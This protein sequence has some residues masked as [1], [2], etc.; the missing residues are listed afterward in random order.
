MTTADRGDDPHRLTT[1]PV[2][3]GIDG[4]PGAA[5]AVDWAADAASRRRR[6]LELVHALD[7]MATRGALGVYDVMV[8]PVQDTIRA[9]GV[10][11]LTAAAEAAR[12][13]DPDLDIVVS[14]SE[15]SPARALIERSAVAH[16]LVVGTSGTGGTISHL[17]STLLAVV[18]HGRGAVVVARGADTA[19]VARHEGPVVVGVDGSARGAAAIGA[20]CAEAAD[21]RARLV[22]VHAWSDLS[23][24]RFGALPE[25]IRDAEVH[26][27]ADAVL[28]E[29]LAGWQEKFPDVEV[30]RKVYLA[31]P[32][33]RLLAWSKV[34]QLVVV[35]NRGRGG[36]R[37]L[38]LGSTSNSLVQHADCPVMVVHPNGSHSS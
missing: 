9:H 16:L 25:I 23:F 31:G 10:E 14:I 29:Q 36:F 35:G 17:G 32:R 34:A 30:V 3:V 24:D 13:V 33:F 26:A 12:R 37:G 11:Q 8:P 38:L 27:R 5:R 21:R 7:L 20:A 4:S 15:Q 6:R 19:Q 18:S 1:A 28:A 2:V 22:A